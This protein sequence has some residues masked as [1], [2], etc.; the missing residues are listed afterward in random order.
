MKTLSQR[1]DEYLAL[2]RSMG[3]DLSFD[4]RVLRKFTTYGDENGFDRISAPLFLDW[5]ANYG[6]ADDNTWSRRLG[7][8][9]RFALVTSMTDARGVLSTYAYDDGG[10]LTS[11]SFPSA[12]G[13]DQAFVYDTTVNGSTGEDKI[14]QINDESGSITREYGSD[15]YVALDRRVTDAAQY[16][17]LYDHDSYGRLQKVTYPGALEIAYTFDALDRVSKITAQRLIIDPGTG[18]YPPPQTVVD[19]VT[20]K[21]SGPLASM[22]YGDGATHTRTYDTSYRLTGLLD[23]V[24]LTTLRDVTHSYTSRDN[25][26]S[27]TD[28]LNALN[29]EIYQYSSREFLSQASGPYD[30]IDY[31]YDAVGNRAT[32]AITASA[33]TVTDI[34]TY[35]LTSNRLESIA[36]GAGGGRVLTY[37]AAGNV[38]YDNQNGGGYGY[39]YNAAGRME[40]FAINGVVQAEYLYNAMGQQVVRR[41]TQA[42]QT[43]HSVH[44]LDGNRLA[45]YDYD[46]QTGTATLLQEYIWLDGAPVAVIDGATGAIAFIR[47]DHVA[48][49]VFVTDDVGVKVWEA[50][51]LP[52]GGVQTAT[53]SNPDLR[54]PGQWFQSES[55]LHQNWMREYDPTTGR[56]I[57]ADPLG[58]VDGASVYG[59][60]LQN[61]NRYIDP[62][63][64]CIGPLAVACAGAFGGGISIPSGAGSGLAIALGIGAAVTPTTP[65]DGTAGED[66]KNDATEGD[67]SC[68]K[69]DGVDCEKQYQDDLDVCR[70]LG[71][72]KSRLAQANMCYGTA[73]LRRNECERYG[74]PVTPL[75]VWWN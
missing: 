3:L 58:L 14:G 17:V 70:A 10:R 54:F 2:R 19:Q 7:M 39:A 33:T 25:L 65:G 75:N 52:F 18:Q 20:Y 16:D 55:G 56:Y 71:K 9:R 64:T 73:E 66:A 48:R 26:A 23:Q 43:I 49:P 45:E 40:S 5:K 22:I 1:L 47:T 8:V 50:S 24:G 41:L 38:T 21:P 37:D 30:Q 63:G 42:G 6:G 11:R 29:N 35:P 44:D 36:Q 57:Q 32:R 53:R 67:G 68:E 72:R 74:Y 34:Y 4:E 62:R 61:P 59:Y 46:P 13:E 15:G 60:A 31:T 28:G 12:P 69:D 51:Y 27:L